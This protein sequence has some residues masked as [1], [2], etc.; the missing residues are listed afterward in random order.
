MNAETN[1]QR[2]HRDM[3]EADRRLRDETDKDPMQAAMRKALEPTAEERQR[4][5]DAQEAVAQAEAV[6]QA[7]GMA[8]AR[9]ERG[10]QPPPKGFSFF[11][12]TKESHRAEAARA[13]LPALRT[14]L[15]EARGQLQFA[16]RRRNE[17]ARDIDRAR[18]ERRNAAKLAHA[19]ARP[20]AR[21][22]PDW[23]SASSPRKEAA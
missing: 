17:L 16:I 3:R 13:S 22:Q 9:A 1:L 23:N 5:A 11:Q 20:S 18:F 12:R 21:R 8:V 10:L 2:L 7:A 6:V 4:L 14:D 15:A 19:P